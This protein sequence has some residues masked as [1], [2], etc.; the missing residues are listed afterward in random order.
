INCVNWYQAQ[1]FC[2]WDGGFLPSEAE[3]HYAASGGGEQRVFPWAEP[4]TSTTIDPTRASYDCMGDGA[5]GCT[6]ADLREVHKTPGSAGRW[7]HRDLRR[8]LSEWVHDAFAATYPCGTCS[9]CANLPASDSPPRV[10]RGG[11]YKDSDVTRLYSVARQPQ[12]P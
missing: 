1:A 12:S 5:A 6:F 8:N 2:I 10:L 4:A 7:D 9:D 11:S 3:W